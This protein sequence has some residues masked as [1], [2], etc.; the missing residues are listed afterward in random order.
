MNNNDGVEDL[1]VNM[2]AVGGGGDGGDMMEVSDDLLASV[3]LEV[4]AGANLPL[5]DELKVRFSSKTFG[6]ILSCSSLF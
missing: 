6:S 3:D 2:A 5:Q 1:L 4:S